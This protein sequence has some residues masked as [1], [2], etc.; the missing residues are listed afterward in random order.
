MPQIL[1]AVLKNKLNYMTKN[2]VYAGTKHEDYPRGDEQ[3]TP[4]YAVIPIIKYLPKNKII[5]C[6]FD[7]EHSE[8]VMALESGG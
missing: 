4:R 8:Y 5:W 2:N 1:F 6:P 7:T 3:C